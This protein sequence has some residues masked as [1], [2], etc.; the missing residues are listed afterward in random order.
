MLYSFGDIDDRYF[1]QISY[2]LCFVMTRKRNA[3]FIVLGFVA[4]NVKEYYL[5]EVIL[6]DAGFVRVLI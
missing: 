3:I 2:W 5:C 4:L 1:S 6:V